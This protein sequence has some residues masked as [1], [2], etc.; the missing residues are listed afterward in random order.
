MISDIN[1]LDLSKRYT[2]ADYLTWQFDEMVELIGGKI[3]RMSPAPGTSHQRLS[4][5]LFRLI[6]NHLLGQPCQAFAAPFDVRL[7]PGRQSA[8]QIDTVVQPDISIICDPD[9]LD[10]RGCHGAPDW[11]VEILS[12]STASKDLNEKYALYEH[13]GVREYWVAHPHEGT[14]LI[15]RLQADGRYHLLRQTPFTRD[16]KAPVGVFPGFEIGL[17]EVF[18]E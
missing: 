4:G 17:D 16:E 11:I 18:G 13:A 8:G 1:K 10:E 6:A 2:Y 9:K 7:P 5:N 15:Y 3:F 14:L 12:K